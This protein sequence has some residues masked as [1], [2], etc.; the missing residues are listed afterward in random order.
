M[1]S[2]LFIYSQV[3][4]TPLLRK[5]V[6]IDNMATLTMRTPPSHID[7]KRTSMPSDHSNQPRSKYLHHPFRQTE[8]ISLSM[9]IYPLEYEYETP[10]INIP[11][12]YIIN[13]IESQQYID[14][15]YSSTSIDAYH[16]SKRKKRK[17]RK[18]FKTSPTPIECHRTQLAT[19]LI[20]SKSLP[21]H[22]RHHQT[23]QPRS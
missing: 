15:V 21:V 6:I 12:P 11:M 8:L 17:R 4:D 22:S 9:L 18:V 23:M 19:S 20:Q 5:G 2:V 1:R 10:Q 14:G 13:H 16:L 7:T 3:N